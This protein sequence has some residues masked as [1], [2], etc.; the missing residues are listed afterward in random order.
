LYGA[1]V[2]ARRALNSQKRRFPARAV[3][4][5]TH[6]FAA[7]ATD[8]WFSFN[9]S[10]GVLLSVRPRSGPQPRATVQ[11]RPGRVRAEARVRWQDE[12]VSFPMPYTPAEADRAP[13]LLLSAVAPRLLP[14][15]PVLCGGLVMGGGAPLTLAVCFRCTAVVGTMMGYWGSVAKSETG[16]P[17][18]AGWPPFTLASEGGNASSA[19]GMVLRM[20]LG[21]RLGA[22]AG[23]KAADCYFWQT[24]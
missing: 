22:H 1:F 20:D 5:S 7:H 2:W 23:Y 8:V 17:A 18:A 10:G 13:R 14:R 19:D 15:G 16:A 4:D 24:H 3:N 11:A 21:A 6:G 9:G 12:N